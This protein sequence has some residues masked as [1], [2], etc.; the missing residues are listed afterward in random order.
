VRIV[1]SDGEVR[2]GAPDDGRIDA[3]LSE[4]LRPGRFA[5]FDA[6][7]GVDGAVTAPSRMAPA[8]PEPV[9]R[10]QAKMHASVASP[11]AP[12]PP[13]VLVYSLTLDRAHDELRD[14]S[15]SHVPRFEDR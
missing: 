8:H 2:A 15:G 12:A 5:P 14:G 13:V 6:P 1:P 9:Q 10:F 4:H 11:P 3:C 7:A